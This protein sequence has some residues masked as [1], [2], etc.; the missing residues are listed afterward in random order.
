MAGLYG[1]ANLDKGV[2]VIRENKGVE[3]EGVPL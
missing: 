3:V 2:A 1:R